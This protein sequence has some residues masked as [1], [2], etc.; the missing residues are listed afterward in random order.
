MLRKLLNPACSLDG[1]SPSKQ[2]GSAALS[3]SRKLFLAPVRFKQLGRTCWR[4]F[5]TC[6][7]NIS[8]Q[9]SPWIPLYCCLDYYQA[10]CFWLLGTAGSFIR[11]LATVN[12]FPSLSPHPYRKL[13]IGETSIL[14]KQRGRDVGRKW[15]G[16]KKVR[17]FNVPGSAGVARRSGSSEICLCERHIQRL[18][19]WVLSEVRQKR[20]LSRS[21]K[22]QV[23]I[24]PCDKV[25]RVTSKEALFMDALVFSVRVMTPILYL[26]VRPRLLP[27]SLPLPPPP[28][29]PS[30]F[31][32]G[33]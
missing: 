33:D 4:F 22:R 32:V 29:P 26:T 23:Q 21:S 2:A 17:D 13:L 11:A 8:N 18:L 5:I 24:N 30:Y 10:L 28:S 9:F 31:V 25:V 6:D 1:K 27:P 19:R 15:K 7:S 12:C 16:K 14:S 20:E 3:G